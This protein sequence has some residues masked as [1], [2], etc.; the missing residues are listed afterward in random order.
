MCSRSLCVF[1]RSLEEAVAQSPWL[2]SKH[3]DG[4]SSREGAFVLSAGGGL[5]WVVEQPSPGAFAL[6]RP[7][8]RGAPVDNALVTNGIAYWRRKSDF[9]VVPVLAHSA[10]RGA[11]RATLTGHAALPVGGADTTIVNTTVVVTLALAPGSPTAS[12]SLGFR[13]ESPVADW[14]LCLKWAA[15]GPSADG[16]RAQG[17]PKAS[18]S[19]KVTATT[20]SYM[21]WPG[22]LLY[23]P[24]ASVVAWWGLS[25]AEDFTN[26]HTW[27][28]NTS[29]WM[30]A[31]G[32]GAHMVAPQFAFQPGPHG[33]RWHNVTTRLLFS[34]AGETLTAVRAIV[35]T[36]LK[37][38]RYQIEPLAPQRPPPDMLACFINARRNSPMWRTTP[39]GHGYQLQD[40][41]SFI[42]LGTTTES[43]LFEY[44]LYLQTNDTVWRKRAFA[45]MELW[46]RGQ[47][48][49]ESSRHFG[50]VNT[51]YELPSGPFDSNDRGANRGWKPDMNAHMA[52][53]A[54]LLWETVR[55]HEDRAPERWFTAA[56]RCAEWVYAIAQAQAGD[57]PAGSA[58]LPQKIFP[59]DWPVASLRDK[60]F[61]SATSGRYMNA[62][63]VFARLLRSSQRNFT[64]LWSEAER[65]TVNNVEG[66]LYFFGQHPDVPDLEQDSVWELV[67]Y[68]L[69]RHEAGAH[70]ALE[71]AVGDAYV[72]LLMLCAKQLSWVK[73]PTQLAAD[74]QPLYQQYTVYTYHNRKWLVLVRL[75]R[76]TGE[77]LWQ[78]LADRLFSLNAFS[79]VTNGS[80][81]ELGG[82]HEAIAD[83]WGQRGGGVDWVGSVYLNELAL[84]FQLQLQLAGVRP[85]DNSALCATGGG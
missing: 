31:A 8:L 63:P 37:L 54:L 45:Q 81:N 39:A 48:L 67:E 38:D 53:Y 58:G 68:W 60:P 27:R 13:T 41:T 5:T 71:R 11:A 33:G 44:T 28:G 7:L 10:Q 55:K 66:L 19:S 36:L 6:G 14:Q 40:T 52:R 46:T 47:Y 62:L 50:A 70:K 77:R 16:W 42:Y 80:R 76:L 51:A 34:D 9:L 64:A 26:P 4:S 35:P 23:R 22:F 73:N 56:Q 84:D 82:F 17:Y 43:A 83:P 61:V 78:Q 24:N 25:I 49:N 74:E 21:G 79:Q 59:L 72:A 3:D 65:W 1:F 85:S 18:N 32:G 75:A 69:D 20:L 15:D 30:D 57:A 29:F 2:P 12:L